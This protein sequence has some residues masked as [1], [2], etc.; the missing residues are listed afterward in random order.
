MFCDFGCAG[1]C[2]L[3]IGTTEAYWKGFSSSLFQI[4]Y[5]PPFFLFL[6]FFFFPLVSPSSLRWMDLLLRSLGRGAYSNAW[7]PTKRFAYMH[8]DRECG[9]WLS[10]SCSIH[11]M[12]HK[13]SCLFWARLSFLIFLI[14]LVKLWMQMTPAALVPDNGAGLLYHS[15]FHPPYFLFGSLNLVAELL[16]FGDRT[17]YKEWYCIH[18]IERVF[19]IWLRVWHLTRTKLFTGGMLA[20]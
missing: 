15:N 10:S 20:P 11:S 6:F 7:A 4:W 8:T 18:E 12:T 13:L 2:R 5:R 1:I 14:L 17:F 19:L 16:R 3:E 9:Y